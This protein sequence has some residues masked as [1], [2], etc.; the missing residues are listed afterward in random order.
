M[1]V[2]V[3][4]QAYIF[5]CIVVGGMFIGFVYDLFRV[6]RRVIKTNNIIVYIQDIIFWF[7]VSLLIFGILFMCNGGE[8]RGY[9]ILGILLGIIIYA[10][11]LSHYVV[12]IILKIVSI[13]TKISVA[14]YKII[15]KPI[16]VM[17]RI[18]LIPAKIT[19][20]K[21]KR[22]FI[23]IKRLKNSF[24]RRISLSIKNFKNVIK[25]Y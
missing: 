4:N 1:L 19:A 13:L 11:I 12:L 20:L 2:D 25:K 3:N 10:F 5:L 6:S 17:Y 8:I 23:F 9:S 7:C 14:L 15:S 24:V 16:I 22:I 21:L 18:V